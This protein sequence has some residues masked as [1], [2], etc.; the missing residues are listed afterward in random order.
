VFSLLV[1]SAACLVSQTKT[2]LARPIYARF[3]GKI[4]AVVEMLNKFNGVFTR[5][6]EEVLESCCMGVCDAL[7][8]KFSD[9]LT[10][11][12]ALNNHRKSSDNH[13]MA[14]AR[15]IKDLTTLHEQ[16]MEKIGSRHSSVDSRYMKIAEPALQMTE[17]TMKRKRRSEYGDTIRRSLAGSEQ[18]APNANP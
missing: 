7:E 13:G 17:D 5:Q 14:L 18:P 8:D 9:L 16:F 11:L 6:D 1:S 4:I 12:T 15:E 2:I 10:A 3:G